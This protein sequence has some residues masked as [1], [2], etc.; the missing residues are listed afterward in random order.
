MNIF[1]KLK[2]FV[3]ESNHYKHLIGGFIISLIPWNV[4]FAIY[5]SIVAASC[6]EFKDDAHNKGSWDW[7]DWGFTVSGGIFAAAVI[8]LIG[9]I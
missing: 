3:M 6:L 8:F 2:N 5:T 9:L 1:T 7:V 4:F